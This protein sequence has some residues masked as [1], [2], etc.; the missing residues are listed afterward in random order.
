MYKIN[1]WKKGISYN[2]N[3]IL[4]IGTY[5]DVIGL[6]KCNACP[7]GTYNDDVG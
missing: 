2:L 1:C 3:N 5:S 6:S 4:Y 7:F